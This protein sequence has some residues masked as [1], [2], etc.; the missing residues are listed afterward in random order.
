[1]RSLLTVALLLGFASTVRAEQLEVVVPAECQNLAQ[2]F[3]VPGVLHSKT[4]IMYALYKLR[5]VGSAHAGASECRL[6][7]ERMKAAYRAQR[8][9]GA[10]AIAP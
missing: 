6:A 3:G 10:Q 9:L 2:Q 8:T 5:K 1:V 7:V 4:Q